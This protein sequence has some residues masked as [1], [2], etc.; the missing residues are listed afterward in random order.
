MF[1]RNGGGGRWFLGGWLFADMLLWLRVQRVSCD[2][3]VEITVP[4]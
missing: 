4:D 1:G 3:V 2:F